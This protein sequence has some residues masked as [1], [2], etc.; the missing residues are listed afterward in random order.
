M[1]LIED[2]ESQKKGAMVIVYNVAGEN[3]PAKTDLRTVAAGAWVSRFGWIGTALWRTSRP[4][5][6]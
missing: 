2:E 3:I 1:S 4:L 6:N 5:S